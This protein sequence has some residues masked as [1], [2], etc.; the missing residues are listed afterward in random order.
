MGI[1]I[2]NKQKSLIMTNW[3]KITEVG[4]PQFPN[5]GKL[6][7]A[8][9]GKWKYFAFFHIDPETDKPW[10]EADNGDSLKNIT[11]WTN[12]PENPKD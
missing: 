1:V 2:V 6:F 7:I 8:F 5:G 4:Y 11:Y 3:N 12:A 9:D 10:W